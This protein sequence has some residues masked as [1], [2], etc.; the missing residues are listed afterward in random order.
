VI[1]IRAYLEHAFGAWRVVGGAPALAAAMHERCLERGVDVQLETEATHISPGRV[2]FADGRELAADVIV[3]AVDTHV[4]ARL[5]GD[6]SNVARSASSKHD[7]YDYSPSI[8]SV[9]IESVLFGAAGQAEPQGFGVP[10][11]GTDPMIRVHAAAEH[12]GELIAQVDVP[13]TDATGTAGAVNAQTEANRVADL[14]ARRLKLPESALTAREWVT[15]A[16]REQATGA[17]GG[18]VH[19]PAVRSLESALL[20]SATVQPMKGLLHIGASSRPGPGV[21]FAALSAWN[22][23]EVLKPTRV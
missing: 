16:D 18:A 6:A 1:S 19:G 14:I 13:A 4:L 21:A 2:T 10:G 9:R 7:K 8:F 23:A 12:P 15:P 17:P 11:I 20:R 5:T 22:A 3:A